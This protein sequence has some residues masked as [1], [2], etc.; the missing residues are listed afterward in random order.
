MTPIEAKITLSALKFRLVKAKAALVTAKESLDDAATTAANASMDAIVS[1][2]AALISAITTDS[3]SASRAK[4]MIIAAA[5]LSPA[6]LKALAEAARVSSAE[7]IVLPAG[8]FEHLS[9]GKGWCRQG[10]GSFATWGERVDGGYRVA[11]IGKW[12]VGSTDGFSRKD[13]VTWTVSKIGDF[14]IAN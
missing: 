1:E 12:T 6:K 9:R 13:S 2:A 10:T 8:K 11:K 3:V 14:W 4:T 5:S 7:G